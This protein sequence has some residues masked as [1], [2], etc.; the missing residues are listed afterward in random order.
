MDFK[1]Y[2]NKIAFPTRPTA[3]KSSNFPF[4]IEG[5]NSFS[6]AVETYNASLKDYEKQRDAYNKHS[7]EL[8]VQFVKDAWDEIDSNNDLNDKIHC[9]I[10]TKAYEDGHSGGYREVFYYM[11]KY[12]EFAE[13]IIKNMKG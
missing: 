6:K 9:S 12:A 2:E 11:R 3:P 1:K 13:E 4:T 7:I 10:Y 5:V 8:D